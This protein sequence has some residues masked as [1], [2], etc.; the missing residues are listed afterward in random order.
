[1]AVIGFVF[2]LIFRFGIKDY[3]LFLFAGLLPWNFFSQ[4]LN[5]ATS[6]IVYERSLIQKSAFPREVIPLSIILSNFIHLLISLLIL[7]VF[8]LLTGKWEVFLPQNIFAL[9][10]TLLL[11]L[12]FTAGLS[13][14]TAALNVF[15]RDVAFFIQTA[16]LIWFYATPVIYPISLIPK[17]FQLLIFLNPLSGV[18]SFFQKTLH[19]Q[20]SFPLAVFLIQG[21]IIIL[22][23]VTGWRFFRR[24]AIYF[25]DWL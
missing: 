20:D 3:Y 7:L 14:F 19:G 17:Q 16:I 8:L 22:I 13:F 15:W 10:A 21:L 5:K 6:S 2:S 18:F 11:L 9:I 24:T 12:A 1:M 23:L 25:S 4:S